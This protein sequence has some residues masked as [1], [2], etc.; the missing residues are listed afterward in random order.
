MTPATAHPFSSPQSPLP[1]VDAGD[2]LQI[3]YTFPQSLTVDKITAASFLPV[4]SSAET[5]PVEA[6]SSESVSASSPVSTCASTLPFSSASRCQ[7][8]VSSLSPAAEPF[9]HKATPFLYPA[10]VDKFGR[11]IFTVED[12]PMHLDY[13][14]ADA[15][16]IDAVCRDMGFSNIRV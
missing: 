5:L 7:P 14:E 11:D 3:F 13:Y 10:G 15:E 12:S 2:I 8:I 16:V 9:I 1:I 4:L 6:I